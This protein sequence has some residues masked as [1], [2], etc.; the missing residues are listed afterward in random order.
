LTNTSHSTPA[1]AS[2]APALLHSDRWLSKAENLLNN[3]A[4]LGIFVL[5]LTATVQI[6]GRKLFNLPIPGYIEQSIALFAFMGAAYCQRLNGHVRM[7]LVL[8]KLRGRLLWFLE[9]FGTLVAM[10]LIGIMIKYGFDHFLRAWKFGDSTIDI[11]LAVWP[12]KLIVPVAFGVLWLRLLLQFIGYCR[13]LRRPDATPVLVP[14]IENTEEQAQRE[15]REA[16]S[17]DGPSHG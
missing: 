17:A 2:T 15:A 14:L 3:I 8:S 10:I 5:M 13:L 1:D 12:S 6:L 7:E 9:A 16:A 11:G 4:A